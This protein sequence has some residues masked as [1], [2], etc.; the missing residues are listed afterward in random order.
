MSRPALRGAVLD[1]DLS[2]F[3]V[4]AHHRRALQEFL[5]GLVHASRAGAHDVP[6]ILLNDRVL[7]QLKAWSTASYGLRLS[8]RLSAR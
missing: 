8:A 7:Q 2:S 6:L 1:L 5:K 3:R 4:D